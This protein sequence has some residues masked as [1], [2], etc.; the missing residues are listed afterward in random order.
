MDRHEKAK[1][2]FLQFCYHA[3]KWTLQSL[4]AHFDRVCSYVCVWN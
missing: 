1:T 4:A 3:S 2:V